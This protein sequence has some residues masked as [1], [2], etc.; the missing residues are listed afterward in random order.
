MFDGK[1]AVEF[2]VRVTVTVPLEPPPTV[3]PAFTVCAGGLTRL[4]NEATGSVFAFTKLSPGFGSNA[5]FPA[6][7]EPLMET[8]VGIIPVEATTVGVMPTVT[9]A[10]ELAVIVPSV[11]I[12]VVP[13][14]A[15][16]PEL[17]ANAPAVS[18]VEDC[19]IG[20]LRT[21]PVLASG[22]LLSTA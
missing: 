7:T 22:P 15:H 2:G 21:A 4:V 20:I 16:D 9:L 12:S 13:E 6:A 14:G 3:C 1:P 19:G 17:V 11:Q 18:P 5:V 8:A 10:L